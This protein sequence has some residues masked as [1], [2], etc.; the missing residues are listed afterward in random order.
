VAPEAV[1]VKAALEQTA[2]YLDSLA[3]KTR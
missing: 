3:A 2:D 1:R